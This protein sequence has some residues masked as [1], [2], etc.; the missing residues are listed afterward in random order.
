MV[1][2]TPAKKGATS[3]MDISA[4]VLGLAVEVVMSLQACKAHLWPG[5][6]QPFGSSQLRFEAPMKTGLSEQVSG[7]RSKTRKRFRWTE[8]REC[9]IL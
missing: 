5:R 9:E 3:I 4:R 7:T 6:A 2:C 8:K 1:T